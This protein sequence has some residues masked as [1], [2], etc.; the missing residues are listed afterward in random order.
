MVSDYMISDHMISDYIFTCHPDGNPDAYAAYYATVFG[1]WKNTLRRQL[2]PW[3]NTLPAGY[4]QSRHT[5][6]NAGELCARVRAGPGHGG[7][8]LPRASQASG[9]MKR[10][11]CVGVGGGGAGRKG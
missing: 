11:A 8:H 6:R 3:E 1:P 2:T 9:G 4:C 5:Q 7:R 10:R